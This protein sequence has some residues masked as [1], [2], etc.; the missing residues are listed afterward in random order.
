MALTQDDLQ[1]I[2][3]A[4]KEETDPLSKRFDGL[5]A[6]QK[7]L[8]TGQAQMKSS[9]EAVLAG[10]EAQATKADIHDLKVELTEKVKRHERRI[11]ILEEKTDTPNPYK[12]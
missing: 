2:R 11:E 9:L 12:H 1:A 6:G 3:T 8:E 7:R 10:Q 5:E 4:V